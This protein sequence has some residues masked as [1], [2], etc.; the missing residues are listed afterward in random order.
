MMTD[1]LPPKS[2]DPL[3]DLFWR[4]ELL[5]VMYWLRGEGLGDAVTPQELA[6]FLAAEPLFLQ[7]HLERAAADGYVIRQYVDTR[8][9]NQAVRYALSDLGRKEGGR[10]FKDEFA[11]M[12]KSGH[13]ECSADCSCHQTGDASNCPSHGHH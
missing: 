9:A 10:R 6:V 1:D 8:E 12:Q 5:Q 2:T 13:G 11:G 4:D 3:D 7:Q